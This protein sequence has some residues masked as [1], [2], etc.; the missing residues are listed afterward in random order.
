MYMSNISHHNS[1]NRDTTLHSSACTT[2][3]AYMA[4][5]VCPGVVTHRPIFEGNKMLVLVSKDHLHLLN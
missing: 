3:R 2:L 1:Y 5:R 4:L